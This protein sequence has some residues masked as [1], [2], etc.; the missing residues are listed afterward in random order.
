MIGDLDRF[1]SYASPYTQA[2][3][4]TGKLTCLNS[5]LDRI[6]DVLKKQL[7][8]QLA[9]RTMNATGDTEDIVRC[10]ELVDDAFKKF[11]VSARFLTITD[12]LN[13]GLGLHDDRRANQFGRHSGWCQLTKYSQF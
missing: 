5:D 3:H 6:R 1:K 8:R 10:K 11:M 7:D 4:E 12:H 13:L 2:A 9:G